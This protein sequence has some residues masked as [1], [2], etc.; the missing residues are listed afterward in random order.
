MACL[1]PHCLFGDTCECPNKHYSGTWTRYNL[2]TGKKVTDPEFCNKHWCPNKACTE[3]SNV[4]G[5]LQLP[6]VSSN[7]ES[8]PTSPSVTSTDQMANDA[9][10][11]DVS[12]NTDA[13]V[14]P[15]LETR[16]SMCQ[17]FGALRDLFSLQ[18]PFDPIQYNVAKMCRSHRLDTDALKYK[19]ADAPKGYDPVQV[20][21]GWQLLS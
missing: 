5:S 15:D 17:N 20:F 6:S 13:P 11:P 4:E 3:G 19:P 9:S 14:E 16:I 18:E 12:D 1:C 21:W 10:D 2:H 8:C 7:V